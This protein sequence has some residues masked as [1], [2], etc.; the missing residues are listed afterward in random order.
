M[1]SACLG[2]HP[3]TQELERDHTARS[4]P[5]AS[6]PLREKR[7]VKLGKVCSLEGDFFCSASCYSHEIWEHAQMFIGDGRG[8]HTALCCIHEIL[9]VMESSKPWAEDLGRFVRTENDQTLL[10]FC[11]TPPPPDASLHP[12]DAGSASSALAVLSTEAWAAF[13][14]ERAKLCPDPRQW[15]VN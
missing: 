7:D 2:N 13:R 6:P 14:F 3:L 8:K 11:G 12:W 9:S 4:A 10:H 5:Q 1:K 15:V